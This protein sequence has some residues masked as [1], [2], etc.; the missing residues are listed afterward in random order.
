MFCLMQWWDVLFVKG[1][2]HF[3]SKMHVYLIVCL[4]GTW[5]N[6][7]PTLANLLCHWTIFQCCK[8]PNIEKY[9]LVT[10]LRT[11]SF[12]SF[13]LFSSQFQ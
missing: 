13:F 2:L 9:H 5:Q 4:F 6:L 10:L 11:P 8:W 3:S 12:K 7:E 1:I